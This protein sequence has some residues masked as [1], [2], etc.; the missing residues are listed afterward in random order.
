M[1]HRAVKKTCSLTFNLGADISYILLQNE[2]HL[3]KVTQLS[4]AL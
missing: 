1:I 4:V 3:H 2:P